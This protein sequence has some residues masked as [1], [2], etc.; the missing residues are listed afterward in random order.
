MMILMLW[1]AKMFPILLLEPDTLSRESGRKI[2]MLCQEWIL[3]PEAE[4]LSQMLL[5]DQL[6]GIPEI[7]DPDLEIQGL[8]HG[9]DLDPARCR[10]DMSEDLALDLRQSKERLTIMDTEEVWE[11]ADLDPG[12]LYLPEDDFHLAVLVLL[13]VEK[14]RSKILRLLL[15]GIVLSL[16]LKA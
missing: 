11:K 3:D 5:L 10:H 2:L 16:L 6:T 4:I 9:L 15:E 13:L 14:T 7:Q 8:N 1:K 12:H